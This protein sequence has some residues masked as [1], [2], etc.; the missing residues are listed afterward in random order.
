MLTIIGQQR[1]SMHADAGLMVSNYA[2]HLVTVSWQCVHIWL[3]SDVPVLARPVLS[4]LSVSLETD[5]SLPSPRSARLVEVTTSLSVGR[6][7]HQFD[8]CISH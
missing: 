8:G 5:N 1:Q 6:T 3:S 4:D 2:S 7:V